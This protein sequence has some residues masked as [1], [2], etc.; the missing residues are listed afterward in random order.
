[1]LDRFATGTVKI[2]QACFFVKPKTYL[3]LIFHHDDA[4][5]NIPTGQDTL[6]LILY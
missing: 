5:N 6:Y 3:A 4:F 1:M 2:K